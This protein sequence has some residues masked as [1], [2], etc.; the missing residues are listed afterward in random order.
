MP[1]APS[2]ST[3]TSRII[4]EKR[5]VSTGGSVSPVTLC[6]EAYAITETK[7]RC[8]DP[9]H[10]AKKIWGGKEEEESEVSGGQGSLYT[11][12]AVGIGAAI[13]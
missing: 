6:N 8:Y 5:V 12:E 10:K 3:R 2:S 9:D 13:Q 11:P 7:A 1:N 4:D